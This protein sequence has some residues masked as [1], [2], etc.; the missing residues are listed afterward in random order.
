MAHLGGQLGDL[1]L[2]RLMRRADLFQFLAQVTG[3]SRAWKFRP[4]HA[5]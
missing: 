5:G 4:A 2:P 1:P 3:R